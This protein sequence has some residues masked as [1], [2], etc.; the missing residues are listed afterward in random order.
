MVR[1]GGAGAVCFCLLLPRLSRGGSSPGPPLQA[2][3]LIEHDTAVA[4]QQPG[5]HGGCG[6]TTA[7]SFFAQA[8]NL[9]LAFRKRSLHHG[10]AIGY[11][12]QQED[13]IYSIESGPREL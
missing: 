3:S 2:S 12:R 5:P 13:E 1:I 8:P 4:T 6:K 11:H 7:Y 10:T 9:Q